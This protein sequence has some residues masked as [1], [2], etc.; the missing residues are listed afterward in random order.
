MKYIQL[1]GYSDKYS[2]DVILHF[3]KCSLCVLSLAALWEIITIKSTAQCQPLKNL[4]W[5]NI[6]PFICNVITQICG[7][8]LS[9]LSPS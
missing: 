2:T 4:L 9:D 1:I 3:S 8:K 6:S 5:C 7:N